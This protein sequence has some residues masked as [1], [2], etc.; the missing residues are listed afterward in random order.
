MSGQHDILA[1]GEVCNT[2]R[3]MEHFGVRRGRV[4]SDALTITDSD[5]N[6]RTQISGSQRYMESQSRLT[7]C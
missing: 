1:G 2:E 7:S 4:E 3:G 6:Q 5:Y